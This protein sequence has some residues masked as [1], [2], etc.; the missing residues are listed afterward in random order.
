MIPEPPRQVHFDSAAGCHMPSLRVKKVQVE[1]WSSRISSYSRMHR[2]T[3]AQ[4]C[5]LSL[6]HLMPLFPRDG[7]PWGAG[8]CG[9]CGHLM[10]RGERGQR[11]VCADRHALPC[12]LLRRHVDNYETATTKGSAAPY[13]EGFYI[14][15]ETRGRCMYI[16]I[17]PSLVPRAPL[18]S[19]MSRRYGSSSFS[20]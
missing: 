1:Q 7:G 9:W 17:W 20:P 10:I 16:L 6:I 11:D 15:R 14:Q 12:A 8:R 5:H 13:I 3:R 18:P 4:I 2:L 19:R